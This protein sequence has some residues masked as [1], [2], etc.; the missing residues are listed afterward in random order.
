MLKILKMFAKKLTIKQYNERRY[1]RAKK[2]LCTI[3][4]DRLFSKRY[5]FINRSNESENL[6][7]ILAGFQ[8]YYWEGVL[9]RVKLNQNQFE[10]NIDICICVPGESGSE[11]KKFAERYNWSFLRINDDLLAQAQNTAIMLHP[12]ARWIY[13]I[14]EDI[15]ISENYFKKLKKSYASAQ[16]QLNTKIGVIS[17][18]LNVN[19]CGVSSFLNTLEITGKFESQFGKL[20][21]GLEEYIH[22]N[23]DVAKWLW[24]RSVPFDA[25]SKK[26][27]VLNSGKVKVC[28]YRLS[29]GAI[30]FTR[31]FWEEI[32][33]FQVSGIGYMGIEEEQVNA[34][35]VN[36]MYSV[37]MA[38]DTFAGHLGFFSQ[39]EICKIFYEENK[40]EICVD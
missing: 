5:E 22:K 34:Y 20:R 17:P 38:L 18:L 32:G 25:V 28:P 29:I 3:E 21:I 2:K 19:A 1:F 15:I 24:E 6:L 40:N 10:E 33:C 39:K 31:E 9:G 8:E 12:N 30:L 7:L 36:K 13:K 16:E 14:D 35:C 27:E 26:I 37:V 4:S 11:L 23:P